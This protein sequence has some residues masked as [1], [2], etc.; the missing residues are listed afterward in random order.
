MGCCQKEFERSFDDPPSTNNS[1]FDG[2]RT[3]GEL[4]RVDQ[5]FDEEDLL[6]LQDDG[7]ELLD[8]AVD[9]RLDFVDRQGH[10]EVEVGLE[11]KRCK[12]LNGQRLQHF[13]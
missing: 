2:I 6:E 8:E 12:F 13:G 9:G 4:E 5:V 11:V 10:V 7:V 3:C 1:F